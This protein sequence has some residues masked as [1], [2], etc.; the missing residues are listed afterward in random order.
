MEADRA[1]LCVLLPAARLRAVGGRWDSL[2]DWLTG[3]CPHLRERLA[4]RRA[5]LDRPLAVAGLPYGYLHAP[6]DATRPVC[7]AS[8]IRRR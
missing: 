5:L 3:E 1:V 4:R 2:L 6:G 7:S 8:A